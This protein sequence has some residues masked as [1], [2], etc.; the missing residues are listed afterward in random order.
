MGLRTYKASGTILSLLGNR[1][2]VRIRASGLD[3]LEDRPTLFVVNHFTR[4][5][6]LV[7]P[8]VLYR[9]TKRQVRTLADAGLFHGYL[10][11]YLRACGVMST[12]DPARNRAIVRELMTRAYDWVIY[13]EGGLVKSKKT[14]ENGRLK[15]DL[16]HRT[17]SPHTGAAVLALR[18]EICKRAYRAAC[19]RGDADRREYYESRFDLDEAEQLAALSTVIVPTTITYSRLRSDRRALLRLASLLGREL[20]PRAQEEL[21]VE[22]SL[23][24]GGSEIGV[25]FGRP[26][27]IDAYL[28][29]P[30][31]AARRVHGFLTGRAID[32]LL[33]KGT[34]RRLTDAFMR[35]IYSNVEVNFD[36]LFC[37]ALTRLDRDEIDGQTL[38]R[39]LFV[40]ADSLCQTPGVRI[41]PSL[42]EGL[43]GLLAGDDFEPLQSAVAL[44][45]N[46]GLL[47]LRDDVYVID[48]EVLGR[49]LDFHNMRL[50][51]MTGVI[52]NELEPVKA[53]TRA[54]RRA[55]ALSDEQL[56]RRVAQATWKRDQRRF[57]TDYTAAIGDD[58]LS[59]RSHGEPYLLESPDPEV[60]ILLIHGYLSCPEETRPLADAL[61][62]RGYTVYGVRLA[63]HGTA[64]SQL[65]DVRWQQWMHSIQRAHAAL[66]S[67]CR[68]IVVGGI[69]LGGVL[70]LHTAAQNKPHISGVFTINAPIKLTDFRLR[71]VPLLLKW[72]TL[73]RSL[74]LTDHA[75]MRLNDR[76][77]SPDINYMTD[78]LAGLR[79][80]RRAMAACRR[81]LGEITAPALVI[82]SCDDPVVCPTSA[83]TII[84]KISSTHKD[85]VEF[86]GSRHVIIRGRD[87]T[88]MAETI[89]AFI[90]K[91]TA[92]AG[93]SA[94][95]SSQ[96]P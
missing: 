24:F 78:Y 65:A 4:F 51:H 5:E 66:E 79:E 67:R 57:E 21:R 22:G 81:R 34:A 70:A 85:L 40:A 68:H 77:E 26:I 7:V 94:T 74:H 72:N 23:L 20:S 76:T 52:A 69:S 15:L 10:G 2:N 61:N 56:A 73:A 19:A 71:F 44:A 27:E 12:R 83:R 46:E 87:S 36:H 32:D 33:L 17:G 54:V 58:S 93:E 45:R 55:F 80:L 53:A 59:E 49:C 63:G 14:M 91:L 82:Q 88:P 35:A 39:A 42:Q 95:T 8:Y 86:P 92:G 64:P 62:A 30:V 1:L 28:R 89:S 41:H 3:N 29:G 11:R 6:T 18:A 43:V 16:P 31:N 25:H 50:D 37:Y 96:T 60:G 47:T 48:R 84:A 9:H 75:A 13:P 38:R 90:Q